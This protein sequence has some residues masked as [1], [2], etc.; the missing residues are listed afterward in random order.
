MSIA[1]Q[2]AA[3]GHAML[4][5]GSHGSALWQRV[6]RHLE[7]T[8]GFTRTGATIEAAG[9][10]I[11]PSFA[12]ADVVLAAGWDEWAG[13]YLLADSAAGDAILRDLARQ[14]GPPRAG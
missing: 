11:V 8:L 10:G 4:E 6:A 12:R 14:F 1:L 9:E 5:F 13:D 7:H 2:R 3:N